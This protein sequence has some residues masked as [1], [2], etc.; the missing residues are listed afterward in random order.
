MSVKPSVGD[1][2][3]IVGMMQ[4][5]NPLPVGLQGTVNWVNAWTSELTRQFGVRWDNGRSLG[6]ID[7]DPYTII[8]KDN[9][10]EQ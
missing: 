3:Q 2:V 7:I 5:P 9:E 10:E 8:T 6:L 4:D 1:R